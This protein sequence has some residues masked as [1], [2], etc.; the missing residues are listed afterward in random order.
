MTSMGLVEDR[1]DDEYWRLRPPGAP[2]SDEICRCDER[3]AVLL[4]HRLTPNPLCCSD[5]NGEVLPEKVG[6][7][8]V[9]AEQLSVWNGLNG[10]LIQLWLDS[11]EYEV[12]A[13]ERLTD[14]AG[15]VNRLAAE[16]TA[17]LNSHL[18]A[19]HWWFV[20]GDEQLSECPL[21]RRPLIEMPAA[22]P[23]AWT[24]CDPCSIAVP[25]T[26]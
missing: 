22:Q 17:A 2:P 24:V 1:S 3:Y 10:A 7:G 23:R 25:T 21:C 13:I 11:S 14:P 12:W 20:D 4:V 19:F 26:D 6:F 9:V 8:P 5:C 18:R 15:R 16:V